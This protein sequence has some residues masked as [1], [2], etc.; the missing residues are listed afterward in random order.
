M[1]TKHEF[2]T[3]VGRLVSGS[4][5]EPQKSDHQNK[6]LTEDKW[7][8][9]V[10]LAFPK[11]TPQ[12]HD[13]PGELGA[14][15]NALRNAAHDGYKGQEWTMGGF[16]WKLDDG[17]DPKH[18]GKEGYAGHWVLKFGRQYSIGPA[19]VYDL[20]NQEIIDPQRLKRGHYY[21]ISGSSSPNGATGDQAG[22]YV[23]MNMVQHCANGQEIVSGPSAS[24]VFAAAPGQLPPGA[25]ASPAAAPSAPPQPQVPG[26][27]PAAPAQA[28]SAPAQAPSAPPQP[29]AAPPQPGAV[30]AQPGAVPAPNFA[31]GGG[32]AEDK[33]QYAGG[34]YTKAALLEAGHTEEQIATYPKA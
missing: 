21:R 23:N 14:V 13:E 19:R 30:P 10:A 31:D 8:F 2:L 11:T 26:Q 6:P 32:Y 3:P 34:T 17:D 22:V 28:P 9:F 25:T 4:L 15:F 1:S 24:Q 12:W 18:A 20:N 29:A 33:Y 7:T 16:K 5:T 27:A